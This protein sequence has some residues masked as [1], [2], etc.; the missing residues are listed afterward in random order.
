MTVVMLFGLCG[1]VPVMAV[2]APVELA[3][4][5]TAGAV[6]GNQITT[7]PTN[8]LNLY[9]NDGKVSAPSNVGIGTLAVNRDFT[10]S[11]SNGV[12]P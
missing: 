3:E 8:Q 10:A 12:L 7:Y 2:D 11:M 9:I 4:D 5:F 6:T 1:V